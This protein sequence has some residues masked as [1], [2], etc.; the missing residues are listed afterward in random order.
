MGDS[1]LGSGHRWGSCKDVQEKADA[2]LAPLRQCCKTWSA[3]GW[4]K[5]QLSLLIS[6]HSLSDEKL[7]LG[8]SSRDIFHGFLQPV[9][10]RMAGTQLGLL[11][12]LTRRKIQI[13]A[14]ALHLE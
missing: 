14:K 12:P 11:P 3:S 10:C 2:F 9:V 8:V 6:G 4:L 5:S 7:T 13:K 1:T